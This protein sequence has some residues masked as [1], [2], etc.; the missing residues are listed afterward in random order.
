MEKRS[1]R[2]DEVAAN[3][4]VH[5]RTVRRLIERGVLKAVKIGGIW[6]VKHEELIRYEE[7]NGIMEQ[8]KESQLAR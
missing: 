1:Y 4:Q 2:L 6:R 3:W 7:T 8:K 5:V